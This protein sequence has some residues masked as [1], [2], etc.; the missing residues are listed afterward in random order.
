[1]SMP[2]VPT[3]PQPSPPRDDNDR[4]LDPSPP[5]TADQ[6]LDIAGTEADEKDTPPAI[7]PPAP[8][9]QDR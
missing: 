7:P 1:M 4:G 9:R 2:G 5:P 8:S 6:H 3:P